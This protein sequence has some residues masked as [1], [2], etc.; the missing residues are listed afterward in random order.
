MSKEQ[1]IIIWDD[2][3][4]RIHELEDTLKLAL[5]I[6]HIEA[7]IQINCEAPLLSRN[8]MIGR[9][10]AFQVNNGDIW[11]HAPNQTVTKD[12]LVLLLSNLKKQNLLK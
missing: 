5:K 1:T 4:D 10:P 3:S 11:T 12:Q 8:K 9:T 6:L 7:K 2:V